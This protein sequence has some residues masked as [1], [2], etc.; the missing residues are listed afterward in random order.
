MG[1]E[2]TARRKIKLERQTLAPLA[3]R[4]HPCDD[5]RVLALALWVH[6]I[7]GLQFLGTKK[8]ERQEHPK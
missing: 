3:H 7:G 5:N 1:I 6:D 4:T 8:E 2:K